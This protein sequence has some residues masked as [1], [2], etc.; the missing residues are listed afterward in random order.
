MVMCIWDRVIFIWL[1]EPM[2]HL[3]HC[4][5]IW[6]VIVHSDWLPISNFIVMSFVWPCELWCSL[7]TSNGFL[8]EIWQFNLIGSLAWL[9]NSATL[10]NYLLCNSPFR[11]VVIRMYDHILAEIKQLWYFVEMGWIR[12][13]VSTLLAQNVKTSVKLWLTDLGMQHL[14]RWLNWKQRSTTQ[15]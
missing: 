5:I 12:A 13:E 3:L 11:L 10:F 9:I 2:F 4:F 15:L 14:C 7:L 8:Y 6:F 1:V